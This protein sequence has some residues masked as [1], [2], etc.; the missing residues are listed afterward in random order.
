MIYN[1]NR[2]IVSGVQAKPE[3][4]SETDEE[5]K[6]TQAASKIYLVYLTSE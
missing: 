3:K 4:I 2:S 6:I 5:A 1:I